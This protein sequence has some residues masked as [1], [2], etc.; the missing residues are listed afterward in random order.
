MKLTRTFIGLS[1]VACALAAVVV[2]VHH[3][4]HA[5]EGLPAIHLDNT[6]VDRSPASGN[7]YGPIVK[8]VAPSVVNIYSTKFVKQRVYRDPL[9]LMMRQMFGNRIPDTSRE[10]TRRDNWLGSGMIITPDGYILTANHVVDG[11]DEVEVGTSDDKSQYP[12]KVIVTDPATDIAV[13]KIEAHDLPAI[14]LGDSSQLEVGDV[15]LAIGNPFG[16]G[17]TVTRGIISALGRSLPM[18]DDASPDRNARYQDFIQTDASINQG[19]SGGALVDAQGRLI[20]INDAIVSPSGTSAGIGFAVPI[21][22][23][24]NVMENFL[25]VG[26]VPRGYLGVDLQ[27]VDA[28]LAKSFGAASAGGGLIAEV[29]PDS[30]AATAGMMSGDV[31][32]AVN[33][34]PVSGAENLKLAISQLLPGSKAT[35]K[36]IRNGAELK[37]TATMGEKQSPQPAT[38]LHSS[39]PAQKPVADSLLGVQV[40]DLDYDFRRQLNAPLT[41]VGAVV[42]GVEN[43][44]NASIAG[45]HRGDVIVEIDHQP[46]TN[47][48]D[49]FRLGRA[50]KGDQILVKVWRP[51]GET[52]VYRYL[53]VNN[54]RRAQ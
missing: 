51:N 15:V 31:I 35:F 34:Q 21:N 26:K 9:E 5:K 22:L 19:N 20:G 27:E 28:G 53:S 47:A 14:T 54:T 41:V 48:A 50:A 24:R 43:A 13:L 3:V 45:L 33:D 4:A 46:V 36:I 18:D 38:A 42:T 7:S 29:G 49:A 39:P 32:I 16:V 1:S 25:N 40:Q 37:L 10:F 2:M 8:K 6:P 12:A 52:G 23:A 30:P 11:A 44:S 17:Q